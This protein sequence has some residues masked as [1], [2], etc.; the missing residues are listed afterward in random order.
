VSS[1]E[2]ETRTQTT[3]R[4]GQTHEN[5]ARR[6]PPTSQEGSLI[7]NQLGGH[8]VFGLLTS[9]V[10]E[11]KFLLNESPSLWYFAMA[12]LA[13]QYT[14]SPANPSR[15][16]RRWTVQVMKDNGASPHWQS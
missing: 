12:T 8:L 10:W 5:T 15:N 16:Q 7:R 1:S 9:E 2:K 3:I 13:N 6:W 14:Y 4:Q 11:N